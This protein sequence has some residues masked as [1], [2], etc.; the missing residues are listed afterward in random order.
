V[1]QNSWHEAAIVATMPDAPS[2]L[3]AKHGPPDWATELSSDRREALLH[4]NESVQ[5]IV[6]AAD[7]RSS[8]FLMKEAIDFKVFAHAIGDFVTSAR[9]E[10]RKEGGWF[11]KFTG[12]GFLVYWIADRRPVDEYLEDVVVTAGV[13]ID[14][15]R[16]RT[17]PILR[18]NSR[19]VP[20]RIGLSIGLDAGPGYFANIAGDITIVGPP[21]V[22]AVRM[23]E[24][25]DPYEC[26]VNNY[27]GQRLLTVPQMMA[28]RNYVL[29][30]VTRPTKE[31]P[32]GQCAFEL[33]FPST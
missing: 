9:D 14:V 12:D 17:E 31:Y 7:I 20:K 30:P 25:A 24:S 11:D 28:A 6:L 26:V 13:I 19:N 5:M 29:A 3:F 23:V 27:L 21:V 4:L 15:F 18:K 10:I 22:G 1:S 8:T 32:D 16:R 2:D 33:R